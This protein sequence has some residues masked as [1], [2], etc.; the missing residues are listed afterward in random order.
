MVALDI[1]LTARH[2][3][4][5]SFGIADV[6]DGLAYLYITNKEYHRV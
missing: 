3:F 4:Y 2:C 1:I 5:D 6:D